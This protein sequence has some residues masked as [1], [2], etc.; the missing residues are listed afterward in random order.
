MNVGW[1]LEGFA[2]VCGFNVLSAFTCFFAELVLQ[3][4]P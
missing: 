2:P 1:C 4:S 3:I